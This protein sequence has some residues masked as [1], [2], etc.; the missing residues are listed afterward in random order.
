VIKFGKSLPPAK[1]FHQAATIF[2]TGGMRL[3]SK[4]RPVISHRMTSDT[5]E[6]MLVAK[7]L[8]ILVAFKVQ[9]LKFKVPRPEARDSS[10]GSDVE[11]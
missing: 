6:R 5:I 10:S 8:C 3:E 1:S 7:R 9:G 4:T 11:H 2:D